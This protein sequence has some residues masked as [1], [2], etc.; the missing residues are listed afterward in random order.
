MEF[1]LFHFVLQTVSPSIVIDLF[2][3]FFLDI[4]YDQIELILK[5]REENAFVVTNGAFDTQYVIYMSIQSLTDELQLVKIDQI[6][7]DGAFKYIAEGNSDAHSSVVEAVERFASS[8]EFNL[9]PAVHSHRQESMRSQASCDMDKPPAYTAAATYPSMVQS[10]PIVT[11][12]VDT[13]RG[14]DADQFE[15]P[16]PTMEEG[17]TRTP[18]RGAFRNRNRTPTAQPPVPERR[19]SGDCCEKTWNYCCHG[20]D[21]YSSWFDFRGTGPCR[22]I[23]VFL[24]WVLVFVFCCPCACLFVAYSW[25][26]SQLSAD[27]LDECFEDG[28]WVAFCGDDCCTCCCCCDDD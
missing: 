16:E 25:F 8:S 28:C 6:F 1:A 4:S 7:Q 9:V 27:E 23:L 10:L 17:G 11:T 24:F 19:G 13:L 18:R 15:A 26:I 2:R 20:K 22:C 5:Q 12:K 21:Q 3:W 14:E